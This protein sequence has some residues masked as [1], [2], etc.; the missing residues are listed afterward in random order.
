M[1]KTA[2][3]SP[4]ILNISVETDRTNQNK[5]HMTIHPMTH[6][7]VP[8]SPSV[9]VPPAAVW[10]SCHAGSLTLAPPGASPPNRERPLSVEQRHHASRT[11]E[12]KNYI[13]R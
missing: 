11:S 8:V 1:P 3:K 10:G 5:Q 4:I 6:H 2:S 7:D 13:F 9:L 12:D